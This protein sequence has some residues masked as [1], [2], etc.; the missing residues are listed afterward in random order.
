MPFSRQSFVT[1]LMTSALPFGSSIA[2]GLI[3]HDDLRL[4]CDNTGYCNALLLTAGEQVR[5]MLPEL[6]HIHLLE[7][8]VHAAAYLLRLDAEIFRCES[9]IILNDVCDDLVIGI[10]KNHA[11][12]TADIKEPVLV[13]GSYSVN[14]HLALRRG[15]DGV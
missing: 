14:K 10:L 4:H 8:I 11:D 1:V 15:K 7:R 3:E 6:V 2:S 9:N 13:G 12:G 5:R